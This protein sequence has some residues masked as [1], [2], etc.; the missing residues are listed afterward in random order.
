MP[1][2]LKTLVAALAVAASPALA[3]LSVRVPPPK[4]LYTCS[5]VDHL[6]LCAWGYYRS[7]L[8]SVLLPALVARRA[9]SPGA[10]MA[11]VSLSLNK[12]T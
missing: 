8:R 5:N 11:A 2:M 4:A 12:E 9:R 7:L 6:F 3:E 1:S 10:M